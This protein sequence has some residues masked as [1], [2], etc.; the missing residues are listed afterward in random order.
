VHKKGRWGTLTIMAYRTKQAAAIFGVTE[1]TIHVWSREFAWRL[2]GTATP[3]HKKQRSFTKEDMQVFD[4]IS[5]MQKQKHTFD[6]IQASLKAGSIG[7]VPL[8]EP[9]EV[10]AI[11]STEF[12][13]RLAFENDRLKSMLV[14]AQTALNKARVDLEEL[15]EVK[16]ENTHLKARLTAQEQTKAELVDHLK[17]EVAELQ[18]KVETLAKEAGHQYAVGYKAGLT[19]NNLLSKSTNDSSEEG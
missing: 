1:Q 11:V 13:T 17:Q 7:D 4:L 5:S 10:Q 6:D 16:E 3:G 9:E 14:D 8:V 18:T 15:R 12:E 2:S 19:D